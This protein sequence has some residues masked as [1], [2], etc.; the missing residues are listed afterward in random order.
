[1]TGARQAP[2]F[3]IRGRI[4]RMVELALAAEAAD[5]A[6]E[7]LTTDGERKWVAADHAWDRAMDARDALAAE[8]LALGAELG[9]IPDE[10]E[11][12]VARLAVMY[13]A[14]EADP[15]L[16]EAESAA[17]VR[18]ARRRRAEFFPDAAARGGEA[19]WAAAFAAWRQGA[20]TKEPAHV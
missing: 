15:P 5:G 11:L 1:M 16:T 8:A 14:T 9:L 19:A 17:W 6:T 13:E 18:F 4:V 20:E 7:S 12:L 3:E 10:A 2:P